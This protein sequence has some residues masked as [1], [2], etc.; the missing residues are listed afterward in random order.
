MADATG[1]QV[2]VAQ[3]LDEALA[4][5][6]NKGLNAIP[7]AGGTWVMRAPIRQEATAQT[8]VSLHAI[9]ELKGIEAAPEELLVGAMVSHRQLAIELSDI[10]DLKAIRVAAEKS[11]N[12][13]VRNMATIGGNLCATDFMSPDLVPALMV[14]DATI[15]VQ[16]AG[17]KAEIPIKDYIETRLVRPNNELVTRI[18]LP[19][20]LFR[21]THQRL[22][23]GKAGEY[24][25][26]NLSMRLSIDG[27]G[28]IANPR[29]AVASVE[30]QPR[31]WIGLEDALRGE[32]ASKVKIKELAIDQIGAFT[33]RDG[34]DA[35]GW[36]RLRILPRLASDALADLTAD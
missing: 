3:S 24:S 33:G 22:L 10:A 34:P 8:F 31:R 11:A 27:R 36:Y 19:R 12:P 17:A 23:M 35:P 14:C 26:A 4:A 20:G 2:I 6:T 7:V 29:I 30:N 16:S 5:L 28:R 1:K 32:V 25:V 13:S 21:S 15:R 18:R 9:E